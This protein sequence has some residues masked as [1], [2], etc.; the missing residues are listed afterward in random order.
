M[1]LPTAFRLDLDAT[2]TLPP[3]DTTSSSHLSFC[4]RCMHSQALMLVWQLMS[5][6]STASDRFYRALYVT[7][8]HDAL[9]LSTKSPMFLAL[10]FKV[11]ARVNSSADAY[12]EWQIGTGHWEVALRVRDTGQCQ[13]QG[14]ESTLNVLLILLCKVAL[15]AKV[16]ARW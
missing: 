7:V 3:P 12:L 11:G 14:L 6:K 4:T 9:P 10:L 13:E 15:R 8:A 2:L 1:A 16:Q 5:S